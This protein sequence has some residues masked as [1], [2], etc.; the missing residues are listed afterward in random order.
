MNA[1]LAL[2]TYGMKHQWIHGPNPSLQKLC[3]LYKIPLWTIKPSMMT[4]NLSWKYS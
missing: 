3:S 1:I 4:S 2:V